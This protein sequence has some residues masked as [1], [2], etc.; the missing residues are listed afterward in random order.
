MLYSSWEP[1]EVA[2]T[3]L[4]TRI[5]S[6]FLIA[7]V[8]VSA[9]LAIW[10]GFILANIFVLHPRPWMLSSIYALRGYP[11]EIFCLEVVDMME[12]G[13]ESGH[14]SQDLWIDDRYVLMVPLLLPENPIIDLPLLELVHF[15]LVLIKV[16]LFS[17]ELLF[18]LLIV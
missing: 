7:L 5:I 10:V 12:E 15:L 3:L 8:K 11:Q 18:C 16:D 17:L 2:S 14:V 4:L 6:T 9:L 1:F 13:H